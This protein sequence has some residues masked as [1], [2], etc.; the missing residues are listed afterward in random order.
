MRSLQ[1]SATGTD[2]DRLTLGVSNLQVSLMDAETAEKERI[3]HGFWSFLLQAPFNFVSQHLRRYTPN[4]VSLSVF[5]LFIPLICTLSLSAGVIVW[6]NIAVGWQIPLYLQY[7]DG[8]QPF[9]HAVLVDLAARQP[10]NI[11]LQLVVPSTDSNFALGNFMNSLT[12]STINHKTLAAVRRPAIAI[13]P[14][15]SY[16]SSKTHLVTIEI[17]M[18]DSFVP[19]TAQVAVDVKIGRQDVWK[20]IGNGQGRELSV[21][22]ASL[23]GIL[24]HK[25]IRGLVTRFPTTF[26]IICS[27]S[28]DTNE[29]PKPP[30]DSE[31]KPSTLLAD[32]HQYP[33][34]SSD[35]ETDASELQEEKEAKPSKS[36]RRRKRRSAKNKIVSEGSSVKSESDPVI[37]S[38][39]LFGRSTNPLRRRRSD[40]PSDMEF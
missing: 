12:L 7:G 36:A 11:V 10:Y 13:P 15:S 38:A 14:K 35:T 17:P 37:I 9:A 29:P 34:D 23:K 31:Q 1:I 26:S 18:L 5:L 22:S 30:E 2:T 33:E 27:A 25:G 3:S 21:Y 39:D 28:R 4:L 6:R 32:D 20:G 24:V 19:E 8:V 40:K 16:F